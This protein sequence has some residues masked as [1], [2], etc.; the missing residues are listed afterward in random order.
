M[1]SPRHRAV[2][3]TGKGSAFAAGVDMT[4]HP[5]RRRSVV[6][7]EQRVLGRALVDNLGQVSPGNAESGADAV[8]AFANAR[9][10]WKRSTL[11]ARKLPSSCRSRRGSRASKVALILPTTPIVTG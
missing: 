5:N 2:E 4:K 1:A 8:S 7:R 9:S 10:F 3:Q 11:V 6:R